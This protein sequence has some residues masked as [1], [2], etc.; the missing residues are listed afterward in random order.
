MKFTTPFYDD[1]P[2]VWAAFRQNLAD[3]HER[4]RGV[5]PPHVLALAELR[6]VDD[7]LI[8]EARHDRVGRVLSLTLRCGDN[9]MG[10][11]DLTLTYEDADIAPPD[12]GL[13]A[14][15]ARNTIDQYHHESDVVRQELDVTEDGRI[16]HRLE[17]HVYREDDVWFAIRCRQLQ[18][19]KVPRPDRDLP[20]LPDR[21]PDGPVAGG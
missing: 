5:L 16:E 12:E 15:I 8:V 4:M 11:Y 3:H 14:H 17:F 18:W 6:G 10:Y 13:L 2:Q 1:A 20:L 9:Q 19:E 7:G 21:F